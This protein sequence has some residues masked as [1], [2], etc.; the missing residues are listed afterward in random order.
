LMQDIEGK[1]VNYFIK[2]VFTIKR[3][4]YKIWN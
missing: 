3:Q 1:I 4:N 2:N